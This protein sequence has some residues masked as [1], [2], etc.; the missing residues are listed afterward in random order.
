MT[1]SG[2]AA[3]SA[4]CE[5]RCSPLRALHLPPNANGGWHRCQPP[6]S[7]TLAMPEGVAAA[8]SGFRPRPFGPGRFPFGVLFEK[9]KLLSKDPRASCRS[10]LPFGFPSRQAPPGSRETAVWTEVRLSVSRRSPLKRTSSVSGRVAAEAK[11]R[12]L[13]FAVPSPEGSGSAGRSFGK[14]GR[15]RLSPPPRASS[16]RSPDLPASHRHSRRSA[17]LSAFRPLPGAPFLRFRRKLAP[18]CKF[19]LPVRIDSR[20]PNVPVDNGDI[21]D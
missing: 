10:K 17:D 4:R 2:P 20:Q 21:G 16:S 19:K 8:G 6:L 3:L 15:H 12:R 5:R 7:A 18:A 11:L 14:W 1:F 13:P 9:P